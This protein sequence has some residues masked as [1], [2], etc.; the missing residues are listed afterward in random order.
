M[1]LDALYFDGK[2][3][4]QRK[5]QVC[6]DPPN[7]LLIVGDDVNFGC[8]PGE[9]QVSAR[10]ANVG[11]QLT[12]PDGSLCEVADSDGLDRMLR[13][14]GHV[15]AGRWLHRLESRMRWVALSFAMVGV[16][17]WAG[18]V[19]VIPAAAK[20]VAFNLPA[21]TE[22]LIGKQALETLDGSVL[23][24]TTLSLQRQTQLRA[25]FSSMLGGL[26]DTHTY[27]I[28]FRAS[29]Q[30]GA[31]AL[32]LPSGTI[33]VTDGL[34]NLAAD[35]SEIKAVLAHEIGHLQERHGVRQVLQSS[36]TALL[37]LGLIG[38]ISSSSSFLAVLPTMLLQ[39][40]YSKEFE[41]QADGFAFALL[42]RDG[43]P[44]EALLSLLQRM[45]SQS[46]KQGGLPYYL[47]S[48]PGIQERMENAIAAK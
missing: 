7:R 17:L 1:K 34:V 47:A 38:D 8:K 24:P 32:A 19:Y 13:E 29:K 23:E 11:R 33:V 31:N 15:S 22:Q 27:Q 44:V 41:R 42:K 6:F 26:D 28:Q 43:I 45:E 30:L 16:V 25:L 2:T 9:M 10:L 48:H 3:S 21:S 36:A 40:K 20:Q 46:D 12:F 14:A 18:V 35:D 37:A 5:V 39:S 4:V